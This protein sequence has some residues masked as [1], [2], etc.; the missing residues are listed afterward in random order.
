VNYPL[1]AH[2][3]QTRPLHGGQSFTYLPTDETVGG[4]AGLCLAAGLEFCRGDLAATRD[5]SAEGRQV[6]HSH[7]TPRIVQIAERSKS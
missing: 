5:L 3:V 4:H 6:H 1:N 2:Q 7:I